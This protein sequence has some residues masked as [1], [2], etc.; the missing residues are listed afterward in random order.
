MRLPGRDG[1][2][3]LDPQ[4]V[5]TRVPNLVLREVGAAMNVHL[6]RLVAA[7]IFLDVRAGHYEEVRRP[8][9]QSSISTALD[10]Y[11]SFETDNVGRRY[12]ELIEEK[13]ERPHNKCRR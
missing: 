5:S 4:Y 1:D 7:F 12:S 13:R 6:A 11:A 8:L 2:R 9:G 3:S 10:F